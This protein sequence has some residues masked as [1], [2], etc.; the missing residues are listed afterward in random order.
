MKTVDR[1]AIRYSSRHEEI[2]PNGSKGLLANCPHNDRPRNANTTIPVP[3]RYAPR[4]TS[5]SSRTCYSH[6]IPNMGSHATH[7]MGEAL[8]SSLLLTYC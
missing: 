5:D 7:G 2:L 8:G 1:I 6:C 4:S 3:Q